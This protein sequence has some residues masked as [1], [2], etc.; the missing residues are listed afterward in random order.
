MARRCCEVWLRSVSDHLNGQTQERALS[1][2]DSYRE[3]FGYYSQYL[4]EVR[5][6]ASTGLSLRERARTHERIAVI[7]QI[8][9]QGIAAEARGLTAV[10]D[11]CV[12]L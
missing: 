3:A 12:L 8:L 7:S 4:S 5:A 6:G 10:K 11:T 2:A 1:A 9:K